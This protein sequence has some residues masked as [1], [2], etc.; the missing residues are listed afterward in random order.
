VGLLNYF[1]DC[2]TFHSTDS[3]LPIALLRQR[4]QVWVLTSWQ[5][6]LSRMPAMGEQVRIVTNPYEIKGFM[7]HRNFLLETAAGERLAIANSVW[8]MVDPETGF[9]TRVSEDIGEKYGLGEPFEMDYAKRKIKVDGMERTS[10]EPIPVMPHMLDTNGHVNN[11]QYVS[12]AAD[13]LPKDFAF[14]QLRVEYKRSARLGD[15]M[16]PALCSG[17]GHRTVVMADGEGKTYAT[18]EFT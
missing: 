14:G 12:L 1:Q 8:T 16:Y 15:T 6:M 2:A 13:C 5:V 18:V 11:S 10:L 7:G 9:P 4:R 3:G 17:D